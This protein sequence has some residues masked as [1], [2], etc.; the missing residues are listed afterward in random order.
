MKKVPGLKMPIRSRT[1]PLPTPEQQ[2]G[3][4]KKVF[5]DIAMVVSGIISLIGAF[6]LITTCIWSPAYR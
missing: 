5:L 6:Y 1:D 2:P 4:G 3:T